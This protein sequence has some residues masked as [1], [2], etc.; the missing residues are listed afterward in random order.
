MLRLAAAGTRY[1]A[2]PGGHSERLSNK[3]AEEACMVAGRVKRLK[4]LADRLE[5]L[6]ASVDRDRVLSDVRSRAVDVDTGVT[7]SA[8]LP[9]REP[10]PPR[11]P[12]AAPKRVAPPTRP[13]EIAVT[14][15]P[16]EEYLAM[17]QRLSLEDTLP[18]PGDQRLR[19]W[20][21]GLRG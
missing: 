3:A 4:D 10:I 5:R 20:T 19:P 15:G 9:A 18:R 12:A 11:A 2:G 6:P 1:V 7:P 14:S 21:L 13:V 8:M 16:S 17:D